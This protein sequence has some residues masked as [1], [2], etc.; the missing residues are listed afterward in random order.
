MKITF[1]TR[2]DAGLFMGGGEVQAERTAAE[3]RKRGHDVTYLS[4]L[5]REVGDLVHAF[6]HAPYYRDIQD[7]CLAAGKPF[8]CSPIFFV[9]D[10]LGKRLSAAIDVRKRGTPLWRAGRLLRKSTLILPNTEEEAR[11]ES[12]LFGVQGRRI[13]VVPN[14]VDPIFAGGTPELFRKRYG[15]E[16]D[17]L[18]TVARIEKRKNHVRLARALAGTSI[19]SVFI[20]RLDDPAIKEECLK[21]DPSIRFIEPIPHEDPLLASAYSACKVFALPSALETPGIAALEAAVT[22]ANIV[23]TRVGGTKEYFGGAASYVDPGSVASI[24]SAVLEQW[25]RPRGDLETGNAYLDKYS[26]SRV[27]EL[28]ETAYIQVCS[29]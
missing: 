26:W 27:A 14:G 25:S 5:D 17:F 4:P 12:K 1:L 6:G 22:G 20:G 8:V 15:I 21:I 9:Q 7:Y 10:R 18:L 29:G 2:H 19:P 23:I 16:G 24:R 11:L 28:T 13:K 3:L